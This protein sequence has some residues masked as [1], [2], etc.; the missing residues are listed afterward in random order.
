MTEIICILDRSGSMSTMAEEVIN[1][2]NHFISQQK[3]LPIT[4]NNDKLTLV[5]FD[6]EYEL[7]HDRIPLSTTPKLTSSTFYVRGMTALNDAIGKT[8]NNVGRHKRNV[9]VL[10]QTDGLENSSREYKSEQIKNLIKEK[11]NLGWEFNFVGAGLDAFNQ[12]AQQYGVRNSNFVPQNN[13]GVQ[14]SFGFFSSQAS[15]Y[16]NNITSSMIGNQVPYYTR[17]IKRT[18][19]TTTTTTTS[20]PR[21]KPFGG[22]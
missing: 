22:W 19:V 14:Q 21:I 20:V 12:G 1:S 2:F 15:N 4:S 8:I 17:P 10:I 18:M 7:V 5:L 9:V 13:L 3:E 6:N 16:R 11:E